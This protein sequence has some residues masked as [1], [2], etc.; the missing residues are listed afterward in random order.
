M[1]IMSICYRTPG[2][3]LTLLISPGVLLNLSEPVVRTLANPC[4]ETSCA[5]TNDREK[6]RLD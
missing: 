5:H 3:A 6:W 2:G 4:R 1:F